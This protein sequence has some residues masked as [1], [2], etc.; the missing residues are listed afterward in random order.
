MKICK[1]HPESDIKELKVSDIET[2]FN[3]DMSEN[4]LVKTQ[5]LMNLRDAQ[6]P[7]QV[8]NA[9]IGLFSDPVSV[10]QLQEK[11]IKEKQ[12]IQNK[13]NNMQ[14]KTNEQ[15]NNIQDT[16]SNNQQNN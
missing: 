4:L 5:A 1:R 7:P 16:L 2:K 13:I 14:N 15:N 10:T 3:R 6:I 11:F 9:V 12:E 8:A